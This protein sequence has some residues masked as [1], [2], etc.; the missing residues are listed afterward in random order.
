MTKKQ[1]M[2][3]T[4]ALTLLVAAALIANFTAAEYSAGKGT[5]KEVSA[6]GEVQITETDLKAGEIS[7]VAQY[8]DQ[9]QLT[10]QEETRHLETIL[11]DEKTDDDTRRAAHEQLI[12]LAERTEKELAIETLLEAKGFEKVAVAVQ[13]E[14]INIMV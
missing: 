13:S 6:Q 11:K 7:F 3:S 2:I 5:V 10:R 4:G 12:E 1:K 8:Q 9:R 14:I